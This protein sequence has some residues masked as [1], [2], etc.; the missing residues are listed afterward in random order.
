MRRK[1]DEKQKAIKRAVVKVVLEEGMH[2]A[3]ISKIARAA[4]VSPA[5]VYIY[6]DNKDV[7][8]R[9]IYIEYAEDVFKTLAD[10][11]GDDMDATAFIDKIIRE[12]YDYMNRNEEAYHF[13][14]QFGSCPSL[15]QGCQNLNGPSLLSDRIL[16]YKKSGAFHDYDDENIWAMLLYP[17]K[18]LSQNACDQS[19]TA[20][21][22]LDEMIKMI[23]KTLVK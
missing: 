14:E 8:L 18:G 13:V 10:R 2:G 5:T 7:M 11:L 16:H 22:R 19:I 1:D 12:Y 6:Y 15:N 17:V 20:D 9:N 21:Q 3:S 23:Q 4:G